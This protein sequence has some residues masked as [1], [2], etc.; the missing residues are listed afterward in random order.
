MTVSEAILKR[1]TVRGFL[2]KPVPQETIKDIISIARQAPSNSNTQPWHIAVVSGKSRYDMEQEIM[3]GLKSRTLKPHSAFPAGGMGLKGK[4]KERQY[5][6]AYKYY[7]S[8]GVD[9]EDKAGRQQLLL[10]NWQF[11]GAPHGAFISMPETMHRANALDIGI[12]LQTMMLLFVERGI[13][14]CP[15]GA[16]AAFPTVVKKYVHIP[17]GN[18]ILCG[19]SFGYK[20]EGAKINS[21]KMDRVSLEEMAS[22]AE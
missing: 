18:A 5:D 16:L 8:M 4:Y 19:L 1:S 21:A 12:F 20:E 6:C 13:A 15:Q 3:E 9:R 2:K 17:E 11:F 10:K 7:G 14:S 22:F